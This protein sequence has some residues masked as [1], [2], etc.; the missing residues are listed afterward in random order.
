MATWQYSLHLIPRRAVEEIYPTVPLSLS[1]EA[2]DEV[3]WW[4][5]HQPPPNFTSLIEP[6][7][8][9]RQHW[10]DMTR[11]WGVESGDSIEVSMESNRV[12]GIFARINVA[13]LD[14]DFVR[15]L[16]LFAAHCDALLLTEEGTLIAPDEAALSTLIKQSNAMRFVQDPQRFLAELRD[17]R[18]VA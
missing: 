11:A 5:Q 6:F 8:A 7:L 3:E 15:Q 9:P 10:S 16:V 2:F 13:Q 12:A 18:Q 14:K 1:R 4:Q 17:R